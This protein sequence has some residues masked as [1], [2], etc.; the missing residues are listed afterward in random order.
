MWLRAFDVTTLFQQDVC[1]D[2]GKVTETFEAVLAD[3]R[4]RTLEIRIRAQTGVELWTRSSVRRS[5]RHAGE[6][7]VGMQDIS[8]AKFDQRQWHELESWLVTLGETL[9]FDFWIQDRAGRFL[10]QNPASVARFGPA[11][12][13]TTHELAMDET[14]KAELNRG[15]DQAM[16]GTLVR[17]EVT[18]AGPEKP[19]ILNRTLA[20]V[21][22]GNQ[23][24]GVLVV[25][26]DITALKQS[27]E[28]LRRSLS[29]LKA[30]QEALVRREQLAALG[31]M[32]AVVA[33]EVRNPLG[34]I[35]NVVALLQRGQ[36]SRGEEADL[37]KVIADETRRLDLL[38]VNLLDFVRPVA[39]DVSPR[40]LRP[41]IERALHQTLWT[42]DAARRISVSI[43]G[44]S[45]LLPLDADQLELALTNL[46]RNAIQAMAGPGSLS[47]TLDTVDDG[48]QVWARVTIRDSGP[49]LPQ[50][51]QDRIFEPFVTTRARG[52]GLGLAIVR[53][54]IEQ[55]RGDVHF[56]SELGQGTTCVVR[57]PMRPVETP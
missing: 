50:G 15:F 6:V 46:F 35:S 48:A 33:H 30:A 40:P 5:S 36:L 9:P 28:A 4:P 52:H 47:V 56:E 43:D 12:G 29:E 20:P 25:D 44:L 3:G 8:T 54:V 21:R 13:L 53:K 37:W 57:L 51:M 55:H 23:V 41:L 39:L 34:S 19:L 32:A 27:E 42:E 31:E 11:V 1:D 17:H 16:T 22:D 24:V 49:G 45:P 7:L 26:I 10:L 18:A 38:V 2:A 14:S